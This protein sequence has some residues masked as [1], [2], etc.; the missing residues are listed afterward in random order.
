MQN[1][2]GNYIASAIATLTSLTL[3]NNLQIIMLSISII[4]VL[5]SFIY[6]FIKLIILYKNKNLNIKDIEK[7]EEKTRKELEELMKGIK[8]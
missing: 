8:K 5:F 1:E 3:E 7:M 2:K 4:S 6:T